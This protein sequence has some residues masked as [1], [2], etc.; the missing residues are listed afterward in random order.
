MIVVHYVQAVSASLM[1]SGTLTEYSI[2]VRHSFEVSQLNHEHT[3]YQG[4][5]TDLCSSIDKG[6]KE[7]VVVAV[8]I[9][10]NLLHR[11]IRC[12]VN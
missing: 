2:L 8:I 11:N 1:L 3:S 10:F 9:I 7:N 12:K 5:I 4:D 6:M